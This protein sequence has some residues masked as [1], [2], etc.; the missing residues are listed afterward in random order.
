MTPHIVMGLSG[1]MD[2]T[3]LLGR[4]LEV[5]AKVHCVLFSYGSKHNTY[6]N[7]AAVNV[8]R[9]YQEQGCPVTSSYVALEGVMAGF[10]SALLLT[11]DAIPEGH[12][13]EESM[14]KTVVP[15]RNLIMAS[16]MAGLAESIGATQVALGVHSGDHH[17]YPDCR[18]AFV[19]AANQAIL[20]SSDGRVSVIAPFIQDTKE[21]IIEQGLTFDIAVPYHLTRTCYKNQPIS[22]G[23]CGSCIE[24]LEAFKL[25]GIEDPI[26][27]E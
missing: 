15:G 9:Y 4:F 21:T 23:K 7:D 24:R 2:S 5:G 25:V 1:G 16:V 13:A 12:Y 6:E 20:A 14:R 19:E 26:P 18:P 17:I 22:C 10:K 11:G 27:Y 3:T 8:V